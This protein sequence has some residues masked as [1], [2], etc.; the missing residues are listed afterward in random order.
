MFVTLQ[1]PI[2]INKNKNAGAYFI[3]ASFSK[4]N[5]IQCV[6]SDACLIEHSLQNTL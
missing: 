6:L 4:C 3:L 2:C 5:I 1:T